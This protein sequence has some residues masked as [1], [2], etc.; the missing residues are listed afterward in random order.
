MP[1]ENYGTDPDI[2]VVVAPQDYRAGRDPQMERALAE[3]M[4]AIAAAEP[5]HPEFGPHPSMKA[6]RLPKH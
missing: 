3:L 2:E 6:P 1:V 4:T 5:L